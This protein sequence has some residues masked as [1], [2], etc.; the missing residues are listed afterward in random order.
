MSIMQRPR[1]KSGS[2]AA[3]ERSMVRVF[4]FQNGQW[5]HRSN[6]TNTSVKVDKK[7]VDFVARFGKQPEEG[8]FLLVETDYEG[9]PEFG[10]LTAPA[11]ETLKRGIDHDYL[12][13]EIAPMHLAAS[14]DVW[15]YH[16]SSGCL[17]RVYE[18]SESP[19]RNLGAWPAGN[20]TLIHEAALY[21]ER[22]ATVYA[23]LTSDDQNRVPD[24]IVVYTGKGA[25]RVLVQPDKMRFWEDVAVE[26]LD[27]GE[28][29]L[30]DANGEGKDHGSST[31]EQE[32][33]VR[34]TQRIKKLNPKL[35]TLTRNARD[36]HSLLRTSFGPQQKPPDQEAINEKLSLSRQLLTYVVQGL[37][38]GT[39]SAAPSP[40]TGA[41]VTQV[42][43]IA[44]EIG[45]MVQIAQYCRSLN[46]KFGTAGA[47]L[48]ADVAN[49]T[50]NTGLCG[51][52]GVTGFNG[53]GVET[54][55]ASWQAIGSVIQFLLDLKNAHDTAWDIRTLN[56]EQIKAKYG[57]GVEVGQAVTLGS[58]LAS[59][60]VAAA[61]LTNTSVAVE[62]ALGTISGSIATHILNGAGAY[63]A[64]VGSLISLA[65][66]VRFSRQAVKTKR[67]LDRLKAIKRLALA[68]KGNTRLLDPETQA[69]LGFAM[70]K[71]HRKWAIKTTS[72]VTASVS[73]TGSA[74]LLGTIAALGATNIWNPIGWGIC[75][76]ASI[77]GAGILVYRIHRKRTSADRAKVRGFS[78]AEFPMKLVNKFVRE[79]RRDE[80]S[81]MALTLGSILSAYGV[82]PSQ[83]D[84]SR[85][86]ANEF[87]ALMAAQ[88][89][90][91]LKS[92]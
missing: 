55:D 75:I 45:A 54:F 44:D 50:N 42:A 26:V 2:T 18:R 12:L 68:N 27:E 53:L 21:D 87:K 64:G 11:A 10:L 22:F 33:L 15:F 16:A 73:M 30:E 57:S 65:Q 25:C 91:H 40:L 63:S 7:K 82:D 72:A 9:D 49:G 85:L 89:Q 59:M 5:V 77:T 51:S 3:A 52:T 38:Q 6:A 56:K 71:A 66:T 90:R 88:I 28:L 8:H 14:A 76:A 58:D 74:V 84:P 81:L 47:N 4:R 39:T 35:K 46:W 70:R 92:S 43:G 48:Q 32:L 23:A 69:L 83:L 17:D 36:L 13:C 31:P 20:P 80:N 79:F 67:R 24:Q 37:I 34:L 61:N 29:K 78:T 62:N 60:S 1:S 86:E 41:N 19:Q